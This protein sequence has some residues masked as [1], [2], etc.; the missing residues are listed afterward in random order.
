MKGIWSP[1][2]KS[3]LEIKHVRAS[4]PF[5]QL[6]KHF[7]YEI[8]VSLFRHSYETVETGDMDVD[9]F[10]NS[11]ID[12]V[13]NPETDVEEYGQNDDIDTQGPDIE[14]DPSNPFGV[15]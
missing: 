4:S 1:I 6:G 7:V 10:I 14:F 8:T 15:R 13:L 11:E 12:N 2:T 3:L 5:F 9:S